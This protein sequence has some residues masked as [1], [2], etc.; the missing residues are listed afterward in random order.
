M[1]IYFTWNSL[2]RILW[3][4]FPNTYQWIQYSKASATLT[5]IS[6]GHLRL[7]KSTVLKV[8]CR[9]KLVYVL[10]YIFFADYNTRVS[11]LWSSLGDMRTRPMAAWWITSLC[12]EQPKTSHRFLNETQT[13]ATRIR[14][15]YISIKPVQTTLK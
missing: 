14:H 11:F 15:N 5:S 12:V 2:Q 7:L 8:S 4:F 3:I 13:E 10:V 9:I 1:F 6:I